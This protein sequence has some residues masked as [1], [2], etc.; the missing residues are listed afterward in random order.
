MDYEVVALY[1]QVV[2]LVKHRGLKIRDI[3]N[4]AGSSPVLPTS[5]LIDQKSRLDEF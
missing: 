2:K 5:L 3:R 1:G 4:A